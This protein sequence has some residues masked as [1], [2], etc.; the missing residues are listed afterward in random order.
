MPKS[1]TRG[2]T[3]LTTADANNSRLVTIC[4]WVVEVVNGRFKRDFKIF[5]QDYFNRAL[6]HMQDDFR[7][8]AAITNA[9][10]DPITDSVNAS[11]FVERINNRINI[12]NCLAEYVIG[13]NL[14]SRRVPFQ[15]K[16]AELPDVREFPRLSEEEL[17]MFALGT[18]QIKLAR[19]YY[20]EHARYGVYTIELYREN[21]D[22]NNLLNNYNISGNNF[23]LLRGK[24]QSRHTRSRIYH[25]YI[26]LNSDRL[27]LEALN[28]YYCSCKSGRR[29]LGTCAH[30]MSIVWFLAYVRYDNIDHPAQFLDNIVIDEND[31]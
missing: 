12:E 21:R 24:V 17:V 20:S 15:S 11:A 27:G 13:H 8:A 16:S 5:R 23:W 9:F 29:T 14:N 25:T 22:L 30:V 19:S 4:R 10:H 18:Y 1:V 2:E 26:L 31:L 7:N 6:P 28:H 3:R